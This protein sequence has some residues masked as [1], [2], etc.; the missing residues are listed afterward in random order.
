MSR[1]REFED[2]TGV[3]MAT[4]VRAATEAALNYYAE[5]RSITFPLVCKPLRPARPSEDA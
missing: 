3:P 2:E 4:L 5:A 1:I